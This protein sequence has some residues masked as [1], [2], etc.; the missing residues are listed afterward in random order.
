LKRIDQGQDSNQ[1]YIK[2]VTSVINNHRLRINLHC[3]A[4]AHY[5][6][7]GLKARTVYEHY[8]YMYIVRSGKV[9]D[10]V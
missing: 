9:D 1:I 6:D 8:K 2:Y 7:R 3:K 5:F 10:T 4:T